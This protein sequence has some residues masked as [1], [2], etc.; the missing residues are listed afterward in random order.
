[1]LV[2]VVERVRAHARIQ[3]VHQHDVGRVVEARA[4]P[5]AV[6]P[7]SSAPRRA[8]GPSSESVT[9]CCLRSGQ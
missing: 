9:V 4:L 7:R 2:A 5:A 8:R 6:P 3:V 1:V